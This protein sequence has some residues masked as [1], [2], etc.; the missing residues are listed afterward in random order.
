MQKTLKE[1]RHGDE[2]AHT[3]VCKR[4]AI[5]PDHLRGASRFVLA[6]MLATMADAA[7]TMVGLLVVM[8]S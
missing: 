6:M 8:N 2:W 4:S 7:L 1:Q 5:A 3:I